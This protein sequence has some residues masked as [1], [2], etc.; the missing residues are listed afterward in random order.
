VAG[1]LTVT[2]NANSTGTASISGA[3]AGDVASIYYSQ[4]S[5]EI[6]AYN[7]TLAGNITGNGSLSL[8]I[9][10][11]HFLFQSLNT[12]AGNV[13]LAR[14]YH[15]NI[16][17]GL[18]PVHVRILDAVINR[19]NNI[20]FSWL[21]TSKVLKRWVPNLLENVDGAPPVVYVCPVGAEQ[22]N[23]TLINR[24][25]P[26]FPTIIALVEAAT[27]TGNQTT[28][29]ATL[30][31]DLDFRIRVSRAFRNQRLSGVPEVYNCRLDPSNIA[32]MNALLTK[33][34]IVSALILR[35]YTREER[36]LT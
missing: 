10:T 27:L 13:T 23:D 7:F 15:Q 26:G 30:N 8:S 18:D 28:G 36:G 25:D 14:A 33:Q 29:L 19:I 11:G 31:R 17:D 2:D 9:G 5:G 22:Y 34:R 1:N 12:N 20:G 35:H 24:D 32:D 16:T 4:W 6:K 21:P 3:A